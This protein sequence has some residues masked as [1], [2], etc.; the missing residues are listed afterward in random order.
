MK[1]N[2]E[3]CEC[4]CKSL[5]C[6]VAGLQFSWFD[7]LKG[8]NWFT[9]GSQRHE[10]ASRYDSVRA[11]NRRIRQE[12]ERR[13]REITDW[14]REIDAALTGRAIAAEESKHV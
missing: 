12:L 14:S 8:G 6:F 11:M 9:V 10:Q 13:R 2:W 7:D 4:G 1:L 5:I 3:Y